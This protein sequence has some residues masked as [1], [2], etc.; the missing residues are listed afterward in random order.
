MKYP[1]P[2]RRAVQD[3]LTATYQPQYKS[4]QEGVRCQFSL[5]ALTKKELISTIAC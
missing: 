2:K 1:V 5:Q 3:A 4:K